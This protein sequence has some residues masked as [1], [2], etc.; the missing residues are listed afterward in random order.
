MTQNTYVRIQEAESA[1]YIE[2]NPDNGFYY[3]RVR[4]ACGERELNREEID[5]MLAF[6]TNEETL[7]DLGN[8]RIGSDDFPSV[9][10]Y[11]GDS[12]GLD[13]PDGDFVRPSEGYSPIDAI[14]HDPNTGMCR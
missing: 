1:A 13:I 14:E 12:Q 5:E 11:R 8:P 10:I 9:S 6:Y 2:F 7:D 4:T 3:G